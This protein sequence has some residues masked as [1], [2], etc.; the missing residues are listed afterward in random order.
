MIRP[1]FYLSVLT[2]AVNEEKNRPVTKVI[3]LLK[4]MQITLGKEGKADKEIYD[5]FACWC[6][7]NEKEKT[8]SIKVAEEAINQ[9]TANIEEYAATV[10]KLKTE[11]KT[12]EIEADENQKALD[13]ATAIRQKA[14]SEMNAEEKDL[15]KSIRALKSAIVVL[16]KHNESMIQEDSLR[17]IATLLDHQ[18]SNIL[19]PSQKSLVHSFLQAPGGFKS[20]SSQSGQI[21]GILESMRDT[22]EANLKTSQREEMENQR[23]YDQ[24]KAAKTEEIQAGQDQID[25]KNEQLAATKEANAEAKQNLEDTQ[26]SLAADQAFLADLKMRCAQTD[27]EWEQRQADRADEIGAIGEALKILSNDDAHDSFTESFNFVQTKSAAVKA[28]SSDRAAQASKILSTAATK[29]NNP[30]LA[31]LASAVRLDAFTKVKQAIDTMIL[32]LT[33]EKDAEIKHK[34][35][36]NEALHQNRASVEKTQRNIDE[37]TA[38]IDGLDADIKTLAGELDVLKAEVKELHKQIKRAGE[39]RAIANK[40]F[41]ETVANQRETQGILAKAIGV[42]KAVFE[43]K[44]KARFAASFADQGGDNDDDP[45]GPPPPTGFKKYEKNSSSGNVISMIQQILD[46]AKKV[47]AE[48]LRDE[49]DAQQGYE[50]FVKESNHSI[51]TKNK[52]IVNKT[53]IHATKK[54]EKTEHETVLAT[55]QDQVKN[56][57]K[58]EGDMHSSC[59]FV[60][61]NF[62]IR[63]DARDEE[64]EALRQAKAILS[65]SGAGASFLQRS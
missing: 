55:E 65:G 40:E 23:I 2:A 51:N 44:E 37:N 48:A 36:C 49:E 60:L 6:T 28:H 46:D 31:T 7:T 4:E 10:G 32:D 41:Q 63:Q 19:T 5:K 18:A 64:I 42:L 33:A 22:F 24:L 14:L 50:S 16:S 26:N 21:F 56:L 30:A 57:K 29:Y 3:N 9:L 61:K 12:L 25:K 35:W 8:E 38:A 54:G 13:Q 17:N 1:I 58:E 11:I 53:E 47:E 52:S 62:D 34:D 59:D 20:H 39:D 45:V 43:R 27:A 15:I